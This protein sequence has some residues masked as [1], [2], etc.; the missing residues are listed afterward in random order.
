[1]E[2][3]YFY[4]ENGR[5]TLDVPIGSVTITIV[6]GYANHVATRVANVSAKGAREHFDT[7]A[8]EGLDERGG[9]WVSADLHVHRNYA[10][11]YKNDGNTLENQA[12]AET[13]AAAAAI[14]YEVEIARLEDAQRQQSARKQHGTQR[15]QRYVVRRHARSV[16]Q[17]AVCGASVRRINAMHR[18]AAQRSAAAHRRSRR[19]T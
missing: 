12:D 2:A 7:R 19:W 9:K 16:G 5:A 10:G 6:R 4:I 17:G 15:E 14:A 8:L 11:T 13:A 1:M 18:P 3:H